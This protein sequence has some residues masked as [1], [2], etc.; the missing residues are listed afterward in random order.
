MFDRFDPLDF[1]RE[2]HLPPFFRCRLCHSAMRD[3]RLPTCALC[4]KKNTSRSL[5]PFQGYRVDRAGVVI[6]VVCDSCVD[7]FSQLPVSQQRF[8]IQARCKQ[9]YSSGQVIYAHRDPRDQQIRYVGR[10]YDLRRRTQD[11]LEHSYPYEPGEIEGEIAAYTRGNWSHDLLELELK[12]IVEM[13]AAIEPSPRVVEWEIRY[14]YHYMRQGAPLL[15]SE[16]RDGRI[17]ARMADS[18]SLDFLTAPFEALVE[19]G[20]FAPDHIEAFIHKWF[21]LKQD[22]PFSV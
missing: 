18:P 2:P 21:P 12:P 17:L 6:R 3:K 14:I 22:S 5:E 9:S 7:A 19:A 4:G 10:T 11:H 8:Y 15:N 16:A 1:W 20:F 13:I